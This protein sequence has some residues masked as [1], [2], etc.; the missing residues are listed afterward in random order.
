[1]SSELPI[2]PRSVRGNDVATPCDVFV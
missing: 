2:E 1:M